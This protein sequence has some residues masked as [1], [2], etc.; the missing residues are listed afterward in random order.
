MTTFSEPRFLVA[1]DSALV[2]EFGDEISERVN[3]RVI[4]LADAL[5]GAGPPGL[6]ESVPT[7]RSLLVHYDPLCISYEEMV[8]YVS[9]AVRTRDAR[10]PIER[11]SVQ[12]P[13]A[14]GGEFGPDLDFVAD[15]HTLSVSDVVRLHCGATYPV[16]M[17]GFSPGFAYLGG[18]PQAIATPRLDT[19]RTRV[20]AGSVGIAG[21]QT[22]IYPIATPGGWRIIGR[23]PVELFNAQD[24]P[25]VMLR[26]GDS[27][28]FVPIPEERYW[29]ELERR[30]D[31]A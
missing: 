9:D 27:V 3:R 1:G 7:Y 23:T 4:A 22:G 31:G 8:D 28:R 12:I 13:V 2:V 24:D 17:L 14:Y 20:S 29:T 16:C 25:P 5:D 30:S 26:P 18:L 19:P 11:R 10:A 6:R 15:Y 21:Y